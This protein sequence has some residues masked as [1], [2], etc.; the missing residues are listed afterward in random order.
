MLCA[1]AIEIAWLVF[2]AVD[3]P[4]AVEVAA[5]ALAALGLASLAAAFFGWM[6]RAQP[7]PGLR[8]R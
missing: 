4:P 5:M 3:A 2:P 7:A 6:G 1:K 8:E